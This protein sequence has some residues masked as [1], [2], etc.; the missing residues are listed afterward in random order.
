MVSLQSL[1]NFGLLFENKFAAYLLC[2]TR[3]RELM[4]RMLALVLTASF[5]YRAPLFQLGGGGGGGGGWEQRALHS[6]VVKSLYY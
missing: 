2:V 5:H 1:P 6:L 4:G 3:E